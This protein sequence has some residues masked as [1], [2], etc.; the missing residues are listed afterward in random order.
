MYK[1]INHYYNINKKY[2]YLT[3]KNKKNKKVRPTSGVTFFLKKH[4][5]ICFPEIIRFFVFF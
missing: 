3:H 4:I 2:N 5:F 1:G